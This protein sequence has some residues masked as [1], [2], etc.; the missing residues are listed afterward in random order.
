[1][2]ALRASVLQRLKSCA[3]HTGFPRWLTRRHIEY[4][5]RPFAPGIFKIN[6]CDA[7]AEPGFRRWRCPNPCGDKRLL[8]D[9]RTPQ[10][11]SKHDFQAPENPLESPKGINLE[12]YFRLLVDAVKDYAIFMLDPQ[13]QI[14]S[15]NHGAERIKGYRAA[16]II[17]KHFSCFYP[18]EDVRAGKP[19]RELEIAAREGTFEEEGWRVRK[20]GSRFCASVVITALRDHR[21]ALLGFA[22]ITRDATERIRA[23]QAQRELSVRLLRLQDEERRKI[24]R[25]LHDMTGPVMSS[26]LMNLAIVE[27]DAAV[28]SERS[29]AA[30][31]EAET[32]ARRCSSEIRTMSYLLHPPLLT[33]VGLAAAVQ[34]YLDGFSQHTGISTHLEAPG[35]LGRLPEEMEI[36]LF[37]VVQECLTNIHRH[38]GSRTAVVRMH[39]VPGRPDKLTLEVVDQ[40][41]GSAAKFAEGL[42][43]KG[44]RGRLHELGG[45]LEITSTAAGTTVRATVPLLVRKKAPNA[46][47]TTKA[48]LLLV[49]DHEIVRQGLASLLQGVEG[50]EICGQAA[51]GE[52]AIREADKSRPDIV[53]MDLRLPGIDGLQATRSILKAHPRTDVLIFTVDESEQVLREALRAGARGCLTKTDAGS[54]LLSTLKTLVA[55]RRSQPGAN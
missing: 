32:L 13:G 23:T 39:I 1:M 52:D 42:G 43:I 28:L 15:W 31:R 47:A 21:G 27:R 12:Q 2:E 7:S 45:E 30:L 37:R 35:D 34:W 54:S 25:E 26:V 9:E 41:G 11:D 33:E 51:T 55:E 48:R 24:S 40:G 14:T 22:K 6:A 46:G 53:I 44:M 16:E 20:D 29:R 5:R 50:F 19:Q 38:A 17:G 36:S 10:T 18:E 3:R 8:L 4:A 49:D